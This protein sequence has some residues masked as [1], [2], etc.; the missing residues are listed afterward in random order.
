MNNPSIRIEGSILSP[1]IFD[2]FEE[3]TGQKKSDFELP[4]K[5]SVKDEIAR[6]WAGARK[7]WRIFQRRLTMLEKNQLGTTET[8]NLWI[9]PLL[10]LL[11]YKIEYR[12]RGMQID[13]R[14]YPISH[15][16]VNCGDT[17]IHIVGVNYPYGLDKKPLSGGRR[18]S[19]HGLM[20]E[21]LNLRDELYGI[22][23]DGQRLRLLRDNSR[24]VKQSYLEFDLDR[25]FRDE[26]FADFSV[27]FRLLHA[28]RLP[29]SRDS[30]HDSLIE[31]YHQDSLESGA[32]IREG[33][34]QAV[35]EAI[36]KFGNGFLSH[37]DNLE[38]QDNISS[39][40]LS[41]SEYFQYLLRLIYRLLFLVVIEERNLVFSDDVQQNQREVY[42]DY[43]S[44]SRLRRL[45]E[46]RHFSD[47]GKYDNWLALNSCFKLFEANGQGIKLGISPLAGD[48][49][50]ADA[51]GV[52]TRC[53]LSNDIFMKCLKSLSLYKNPNNGQ[54]IR[55]NYAAL[56]VEEFGSVYEGLLESE[57]KFTNLQGG[58]RFN[59]AEGRERADTG[60]HY[61]PDDLVQPLIR[62][63]LD[64][65]I[66]ECLIADDPESAL[67]DLKVAD[68]TCGSGH[69]LL[70]AARRIAN[71]LATVRTNEEQPSPLAY[72][73][74]LRD[75]VRNCIYGV[76]LNPLA[77]E[78]CKVAL[79]LE[80]HSPGEPLNFLDHHIKCGNA[81]LGFA[82]REDVSVG[83]PT[84]AFKPIQNDDK[85]IASEFRS[86]N[87]K[88]LKHKDQLPI[89]FN[90]LLKVQV[91]SVAEEF[92]SL[93]SLPE[94]SLD[95]IVEKKK[96][97]RALE[98]TKDVELLKTISDVPIAQ[99]FIPKDSENSGKLVTD[100]KFREFFWAG[101]RTYSIGTE[102]AR[103]LSKEKNIFH[104]FLEF[105]EV[106]EKGGFDCI[107]GNPPYMGGQR[108]SGTFGYPFCQCMR[109]LYAPAG[110]SELVV[111]FIRRVHTLLRKNG[112]AAVIT[113][114]SIKDGRVR[115]DGLE[116]IVLTGSEIN[117]AIRNIKWPGT[118]NLVV[119]LLAFYKGIWRGLKF[120]D[121]SKVEF[122]NT[123][124]E[125]NIIQPK[126][127]KLLENQNLVFQG[128]I[129]LG[130][131]FL[132]TH[133]EAKQFCETAPENS[134]V[135]MPI[136][137]GKEINNNPVQK[138]GRCIINFRDWPKKRAQNYL[139]PFSRVEEKV[140]PI[141]EKQKIKKRRELW[142]IFAGSTP[143]LTESLSKLSRC[144]VVARTTKH[145]SFSAMPTDYVFS[146]A[147]FV[148][149]T[150]RWDLFSVVQSTIHE[151]WARKYSGS[152]KTHL[153]YTSTN[154]F[155]TFAFPIGLMQNSNLNVATL[156]DR[157]HT[158]RKSIMKSLWIG[159]T[160]LYNLFHDPNLSKDLIMKIS[161]KNFEVSESGFQDL[162]E[163]RNLQYEIDSA[164]LELYGWTDLKFEYDFHELE[165]LSEN[166]RVRY[167]IAKEVRRELLNRLLE[168]NLSRT[169]EQIASGNIGK[170]DKNL[171]A[172]DNLFEKIL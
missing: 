105:P 152:L 106:M 168:E 97:F 132:L 128:S 102:T 92:N 2:Q 13:G 150:D 170:G 48:L 80:A 78:L 11:S 113:T 142:W 140:K 141:R 27:L 73:A 162:I 161:K 66:Q 104:W 41:A 122:I 26:L 21:F 114:N 155:N 143:A 38:L 146:D 115:K 55:I 33:L 12:H 166:D 61:T 24:L 87:K 40:K 29:K 69:I 6:S 94:N 35:R 160:T 5:T 7:Y 53:T 44:V 84:E 93:A 9:I 135:I 17:P 47:S 130:N 163:L 116:Q 137:N 8:R 74:A 147:T 81:I 107:L 15:R 95:E 56:N 164:I 145:L 75:V 100:A 90:N 4:Y 49:F 131:G 28:T 109:W 39:N 136:I 139:I 165:Y 59:L 159:L 23:T 133:D 42:R 101:N 151:I 58:L 171:V 77:I 125:D 121:N 70:A 65:L 103:L 25:I 110:L 83:V 22:V 88:E 45:S 51:L 76:D 79:W 119:S 108:L 43:Y 169:N 31:Q 156:G 64:Y 98:E 158:L 3:L 52:L 127:Q 118:A 62:H 117:M 134:E 10:G 96:Q 30:A 126:P 111:Y 19:A 144:F 18:I 138:P 34:S 60:S 124:L 67:L 82:K 16:I 86:R 112:F 123:Y 172:K 54:I 72:R 14:K 120:L 36:L 32:R 1:D 85:E 89:N 71:T 63:S 20:Q 153:R 50:S 149:T 37:S 157:Y 167:T 68:I 99:F 129:F 57:P 148:F 154:C 46:L 91:T